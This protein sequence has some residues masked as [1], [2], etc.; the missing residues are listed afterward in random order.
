MENQT[1]HLTM[2]CGRLI[3]LSAIA[4]IEVQLKVSTIMLTNSKKLDVEFTCILILQAK[5]YDKKA[6]I[7]VPLKTTMDWEELAKKFPDIILH[8]KPLT[9]NEEQEIHSNK[10]LLTKKQ[11]YWIMANIQKEIHTELF[12]EYCLKNIIEK[13][14]MS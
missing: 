12:D 11:R 13:Q 14:V 3:D 10:C 1:S 6:T 5:Y 2:L 8:L 4:S 9:L 7:K